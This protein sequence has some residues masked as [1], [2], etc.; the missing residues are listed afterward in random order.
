MAKLRRANLSGVRHTYVRL[1]DFEMRRNG[2][3]GPFNELN[4]QSPQVWGFSKTT[5]RISIA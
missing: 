4:S 1:S 2:E 3:I 5:D